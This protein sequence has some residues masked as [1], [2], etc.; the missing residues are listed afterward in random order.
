MEDFDEEAEAAAR[1]KE[2]EDDEDDE[3]LV[4]GELSLSL[5]HLCKKNT[6]ARIRQ[7][8]EESRFL[9]FLFLFQQK[10]FQ[11]RLKSVMLLNCKST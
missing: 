6:V 4:G 10:L 2:E 1:P 7:Y 3:G 8:V 5:L 9:K 11:G